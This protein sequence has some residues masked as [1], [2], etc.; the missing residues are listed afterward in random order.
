MHESVFYYISQKIE[1]FG[2][3]KFWCIGKVIASLKFC[4]WILKS[5]VKVL[6]VLNNTAQVIEYFYPSSVDMQT[7]WQLE[8]DESFDQRSRHIYTVC[9]APL[10]L[11]KPRSHSSNL[12]PK[13]CPISGIQFHGQSFRTSSF[14]KMKWE[15]SKLNLSSSTGTHMG[16]IFLYVLVWVGAT[17]GII[18]SN[19]WHFYQ[20]CQILNS[21][22][23]D[24]D[25][26]YIILLN[27][28]CLF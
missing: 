18:S 12:Q 8:T 21:I 4:S 26:I 13:C 2:S 27:N 7:L 20:K 1:D 11:P 23:M 14:L 10:N 19:G 15:F 3:C 22:E 25:V 5:V 9:T 16:F 24:D 6:D 17:E 28:Y